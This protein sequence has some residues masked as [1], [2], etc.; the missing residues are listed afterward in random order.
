M[1]DRSPDE[2][3]DEPADDATAFNACLRRILPEDQ[4]HHVLQV[5]KILSLAGV[6]ERT[7]EM[8]RYQAIE[9]DLEEIEQGGGE[10]HGFLRS[11]CMLMKA[12]IGDDSEPF[13]DE[14]IIR[15]FTKLPSSIQHQLVTEFWSEDP[16]VA[17]MLA[18]I[19]ELNQTEV[20]ALIL[21]LDREERASAVPPRS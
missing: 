11:A 14:F 1:I 19:L 4:L 15:Q 10:L 7:R 3:L 6:A 8:E 18:Q 5:E 16:E 17:A 13:R 2:S 12:H 9:T 20:A 21:W